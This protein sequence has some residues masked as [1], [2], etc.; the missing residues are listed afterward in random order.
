MK[1]KQ[2]LAENQTSSSAFSQSFILLRKCRQM[3]E[4]GIMQAQKEFKIKFMRMKQQSNNSKKTGV[5]KLDLQELHSSY[6]QTRNRRIK[7]LKYLQDLESTIMLSGD[8]EQVV[9]KKLRICRI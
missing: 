5:S 9:S 7:T 1:M 8:V 3:F 6:T 4:V 2:L